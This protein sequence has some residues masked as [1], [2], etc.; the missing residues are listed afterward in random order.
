MNR[1]AQQRPDINEVEWTNHFKRAFGTE[2][3]SA[4]PVVIDEADPHSV[5]VLD[6]PITEEEII[7]AVED[8]KSKKLP[9]TDGIMAEMIK[10]SLPQILPFIF[11][12]LVALFNRIF[13]TG[14]YP[15]AWTGAIIIPVHK[16]GNKND[17]DNY[18]GW[19]W[20]GVSL[21]S[22]LGKVFAHI[23]NKRLSWW[24][25]ESNKIDEEQSGF[26]TGYSTMDNV[27]VL[28]AMFSGT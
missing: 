21:L 20:G 3:A 10:T 28:N 5:D 22:I 18:R 17:P 26:R 25:E 8:L 2:S 19:G 1:V 15:T 4:Q 14:E 23:L 7:R 24:Q 12:F 11:Y 9:G 27:F 13:D 6:S 16:G